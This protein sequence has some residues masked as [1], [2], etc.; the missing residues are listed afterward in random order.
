MT[1]SFS[2]HHQ[3]SDN[4]LNSEDLTLIQ[5]I[6]KVKQ[7]WLRSIG[8]NTLQAL[9][10]ASPEAL[11][12]QLASDGYVAHTSEVERWISQA[13][14]LLGQT[15][16]VAEMSAAINPIEDIK[17]AAPL[18][19]SLEVWQTFAAFT[20]EFQ[21]CGHGEQEV[22][23]RTLVR[24]VA[25]EQEEIWSGIEASDL[26]VWLR[27]QVADVMPTATEAA[28]LTTSTG[29]GDAEETDLPVAP[30]IEDL[31]LLQPSVTRKAMGLHKPNMLF[32]APLKENSPFSIALKFG[33][34]DQEA[35][36]KLKRAMSYQ[37]ECYARSLNGGD[38]IS[39][40]QLPQT[41][42]FPQKSS[43][44]AYLPTTR[45]KKG[46]YR[47]QVFLNLQGVQALP[48]FLEIPVL[49]VV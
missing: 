6:G 44:T 29:E 43:Y 15:G 48:T 30:V 41:K 33:I 24:H 37:V 27:S 38:I 10:E 13:Q 40:G 22:Q 1:D 21:A 28:D 3:T 19:Q 17:D 5:G 9:S 47:L 35:L 49:Q 42:L 14:V 45:L 31:Y 20:V 11:H 8:I 2:Y 4:Q 39:L 25:T 12:R 26:Q 46:L 7:L 18:A 16:A 34:Q 23:R 36:A 32:P